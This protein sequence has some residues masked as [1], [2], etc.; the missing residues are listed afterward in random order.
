MFPANLPFVGRESA[1]RVG[2]KLEFH[3]LGGVGWEF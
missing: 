2:G 3:G 1:V